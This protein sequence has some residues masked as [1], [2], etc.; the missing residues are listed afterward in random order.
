VKVE[1]DQKIIYTVYE[2][3]TINLPVE[4]NKPM[5]I[6]NS[7]ASLEIKLLSGKSGLEYNFETFNCI[8]ISTEKG[9]LKTKGKNSISLSIPAGGFIRISQLK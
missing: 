2:D 6:I 3:Y 7:K 4:L 5:D 1:N 8:G 9:I